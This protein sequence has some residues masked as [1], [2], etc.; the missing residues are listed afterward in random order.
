M[1]VGRSAPP[2]RSSRGPR[3]AASGGGQATVEFA[4]VLPVLLLAM[5]FVVQVASIGLAQILVVQ[6]ARNAARAA[7]VDPAP[8]A[9]RAAA[10][11]T[12]GLRAD[13][14]TVEVGTRGPPGTL[15]SVT[16]R[17]RAPTDVPLVGALVGDVVLSA[18]VSVQV[19]DDSPPTVVT[20]RL[21]VRSSGRDE[22]AGRSEARGAQQRPGPGL[23]ERFVPAPALR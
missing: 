3:G 22:Q 10:V 18:T 5:V 16:V 17:Y 11:G 13:R 19:E 15:V 12:S 9:A 23:V 8:G 4:L 14:T 20:P 2:G 6:A 21:S 1:R 7:A